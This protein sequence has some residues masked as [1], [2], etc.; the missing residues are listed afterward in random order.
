M[1]IISLADCCRL[2]AIDPKTLRRWLAQAQ[3]SVEAH[4][5]DARIKGLRRD[6]LLLLAR[7]HRRSLAGLPEELAAPATTEQAQES[8]ALSPSLSDLLQ[9]LSELPAQ[10]AALQQQLA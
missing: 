7:A 9:T 10:I 3:L 1:P 8:P 6:H 5:T 2:L 4:P